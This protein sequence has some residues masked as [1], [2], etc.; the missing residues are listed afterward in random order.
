MIPAL[1]AAFLAGTVVGVAIMVREG[2][3][4]RKKGVPFGPFLALGGLLA[5]LAGPEL[6]ELYRS[7]FLA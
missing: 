2:A 6:I 5:V 3:G 1:F 4:A 7:T